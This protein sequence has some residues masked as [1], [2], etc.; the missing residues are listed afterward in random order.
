MKVSAVITANK[1]KYESTGCKQPGIIVVFIV[2]TLGLICGCVV[3]TVSDDSLFSSLGKYF[4]SFTTDFSNKNKPEIFSGLLLSDIPYFFVMTVLGLS[5][6][7]YIPGLVFSFIKCAGIGAVSTHL[8]IT[9]SLKGIEYCILM[10]FPSY[11]VLIFAVMILTHSCYVTSIKINNLIR[12]KDEP[13]IEIRKYLLRSVLIYS[14]FFTA[15]LVR[16]FAIIS[17]SSLFTFS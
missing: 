1:L 5:A 6:L 13:D 14:M 8:Y 9:Y 15:T 17:F 11:A 4:I 3:Y 16:F 2:L 12:S 7:G 10:L